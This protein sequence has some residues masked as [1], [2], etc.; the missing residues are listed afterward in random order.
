MHVSLGRRQILVPGKLLYRPRWSTFQ[1][2]VQ[3]E[4]VTQTMNPA[5]G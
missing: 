4:A 3:T 1:R 2:Q 5:V